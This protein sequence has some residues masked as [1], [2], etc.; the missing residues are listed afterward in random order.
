MQGRPVIIIP[1]EVFIEGTI[2]SYTPEV[3][4]LFETEIKKAFSLVDILG[5]HYSLQVKRGEPALKNSSIVNHFIKEV[6][7]E[8]SPNNQ[9]VNRPFGLGGE[10]FGYVTQKLPAAMFFLGCA[11][12]DGIQRNLHT[13]IFDIDEK[14][15]PLG[16]AILVQTATK[17][18]MNVGKT[19]EEK[20]AEVETIYA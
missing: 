3:R 19:S 14:C 17:L 2:R 12:A 16:A 9:I 6:I 1:T 7:A 18:L 15:L 10:D 8:I 11:P 4:D 20:K 13:P 5:G